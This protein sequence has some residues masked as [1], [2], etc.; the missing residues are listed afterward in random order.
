MKQFLT[1]GNSFA[2][3]NLLF[4]AVFG[5]FLHY[6]FISYT[7]KLDQNVSFL[8]AI[9]FTFIAISSVAA[10]L[11]FRPEKMKFS[12][13]NLL[14]VSLILL[15]V[16]TVLNI[17]TSIAVTVLFVLLSI[18]YGVVHKKIQ[19]PH[20]LFYF[21]AGYYIFQLLGLSWSI[22]LKNGLHTIDKGISYIIIPLAFCLYPISDETR[23]KLLKIFFRIMF[24]FVLVGLIGYIYQVYFNKIGLFAGFS[25]NKDYLN[26]KLENN[27]AYWAIMR[28]SRYG[29][30]TFVSFIL[31]LTFGI[32]V[33]FH[34]MEKEFAK[35]ISIFELLLFAGFAMILIVLLQSRLGMI[36]FPFGVFVSTFWALRKRKKLV[37]SLIGVVA[38]MVA[39]CTLYLFKFHK[40][41]F[42]DSPRSIMLERTMKFIHEHPLLGTGTGGMRKIAID[43]ANPHNQYYGEILHLGIV[44]FIVMAILLGA[45][46]YFG[47]KNKNMLLL[48]FTLLF[49]MLMLTEM[50]LTIQKGITYFSLFTCLFIRPEWGQENL[51]LPNSDTKP[52]ITD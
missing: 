33:Y 35:R 8:T 29:H 28:W 38:F 43:F 44:G 25:L 10:L 26:S 49:L 19:K 7:L 46:I 16:S 42:F 36:L 21:I 23:K 41:Y 1:K 20:P 39:S 6:F 15:L 17:P 31:V 22:D 4:F 12:V 9:A 11:V 18:V 48:Y 32:G 51:K 2:I 24:V 45:T 13:E 52:Q 47:V 5:I 3:I 40:S 14:K 27:S 34:D 50:P 30:P 37:F